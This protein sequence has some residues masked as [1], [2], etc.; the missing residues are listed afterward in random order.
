[1]KLLLLLLQFAL[2]L[3]VLGQDYYVAP[4]GG[5]GNPGSLEKPCHPSASSTGGSAAAGD[6]S[7]RDVDRLARK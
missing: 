1:M 3:P 2:A 5:D 4:S 7:G 6:T